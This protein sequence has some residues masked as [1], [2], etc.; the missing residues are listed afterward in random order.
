[1]RPAGTVSLIASA[2]ALS[3]IIALV[4]G[5]RIADYLTL[6]T[7]LVATFLVFAL[8]LT[9]AIMG[10]RTR[11]RRQWLSCLVVSLASM[12]LFSSST[13]LGA[14]WILIKSATRHIF[15]MPRRPSPTGQPGQAS[16]PFATTSDG[17]KL[18]HSVVS[19][20]WHSDHHT[21][22]AAR[23]VSDTVFA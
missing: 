1:M 7:Q 13:P 23:L 2:I 17:E 18:T 5:L 21:I 12:V 20:V 15:I 3:A 10:L 16:Q 6:H 9:V 4:R 8:N 11:F 19:S 22:D 14:A